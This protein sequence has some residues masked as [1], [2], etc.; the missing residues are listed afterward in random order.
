MPSLTNTHLFWNEKKT[1]TFTSSLF[2]VFSSTFINILTLNQYKFIHKFWHLYGIIWYKQHRQFVSY[3]YIYIKCDISV[4]I[5]MSCTNETAWYIIC[6]CFSI[7]LVCLMKLNIVRANLKISSNRKSNSL[8]TET[9]WIQ[10]WRIYFP[11]NYE[12]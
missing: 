1:Y 6:A 12:S 8:S 10:K 2:N 4:C 7:F 11:W 3:W 9:D 5:C